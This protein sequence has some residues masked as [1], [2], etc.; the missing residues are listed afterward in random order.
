MEHFLTT[1]IRVWEVKWTPEENFSLRRL[2]E[3]TAVT[4]PGPSGSLAP[5][6]T[7]QTL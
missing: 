5:G 6:R 7:H 1:P 4:I 3:G 2:G